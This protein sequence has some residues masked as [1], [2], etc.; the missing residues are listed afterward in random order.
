MTS[1]NS[2]RIALILS[3][4]FMNLILRL[5]LGGTFILSAVTKLPHHTEFVEIVKDYDLLPNFLATGYGNALPWIELVVGVY[6]ILG[7]LPKFS[8]TIIILMAVSFMVANIR[9]IARGE[10]RCGT[11]F[12][13][14][15]TLPVWQAM[16]IDVLILIAALI[17]LLVK[18]RRLLFSLENLVLNRKGRENINRD[19]V[20]ENRS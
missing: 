18:S 14:T 6:I 3:H 13:E 10:D 15:I 20:L 16:T 5:F 9:S 12:G 17:L 11:C 1:I 4:P 7:I 8:A 19:N 2:K